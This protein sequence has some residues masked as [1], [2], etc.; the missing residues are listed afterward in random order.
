MNNRRIAARFN[1][2]ADRLALAKANPYRVQAYRKAARILE[3]LKEDVA[4][5]DERDQLERIPGIGRD[6]AGKIRT[7]LATGEIPDPSIEAEPGNLPQ[8]LATF[9]SISGLDPKLIGLLYRR[10]RIESLDD[11]ERLA[12]SHLLRTLP[13]LGA[14][15]EQKILHGL[16]SLKRKERK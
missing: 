16:E 1:E 3:R 10:F 6:L 9:V 7:F 5:L 11:L 15:W 8:E 2:I 14:Q 12:R 4:R 13:H